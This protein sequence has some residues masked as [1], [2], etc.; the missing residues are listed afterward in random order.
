MLDIQNGK[1]RASCECDTQVVDWEWDSLLCSNE[2][3]W[4]IKTKNKQIKPWQAR[5]CD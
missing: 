3:H 4:G 2:P 5:G 1:K